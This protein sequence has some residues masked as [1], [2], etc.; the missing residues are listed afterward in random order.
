MRK[1]SRTVYL[2]NE[3]AAVDVS[4][5]NR[6]DP[7]EHLE[8]AERDDTGTVANRAP[9]P[10]ANVGTDEEGESAPTSATPDGKMKSDGF[11]ET[12][13]VE[14]KYRLRGAV[15]SCLDC[16]AGSAGGSSSSSASQS[17][18]PKPRSSDT[19]SPARDGILRTIAIFIMMIILYNARPRR[20]VDVVRAAGVLRGVDQKR[21]RNYRRDATFYQEFGLTSSLSDCFMMRVST[22]RSIADDPHL[23]RLSAERAEAEAERARLSETLANASNVDEEARLKV[24]EA[25]GVQLKR[26]KEYDEEEK[27]Y[28]LQHGRVSEFSASPEALLYAAKELHYG[29]YAD[30]KLLKQAKAGITEGDPKEVQ[31]DKW[32]RLEEELRRKAFELKT[33]HL[34]PVKEKRDKARLDLEEATTVSP[35]VPIFSLNRA[36]ANPGHV[37]WVPLP[38]T[39]PFVDLSIISTLHKQHIN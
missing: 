37:S 35:C 32:N 12:K 17:T 30:L 10:S 36:E 31:K 14:K 39:C 23:S 28:Q 6:S 8:G 15:K 1:L 18:V 24:E 16:S 5:H 22:L 26:W 25:E 29:E 27:A 3:V 9:A 38:A 11:L 34:Q 13:K 21:H 33:E 20:G 4:G 2:L 7:A 19:P